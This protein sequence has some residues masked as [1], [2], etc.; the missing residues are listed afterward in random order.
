MVPCT[1]FYIQGTCFQVL[2]S[3]NKICFEVY[4]CYVLTYF[5]VFIIMSTKLWRLFLWVFL[6]LIFSDRYWFSKLAWGLGYPPTFCIISFHFHFVLRIDPTKLWCEIFLLFGR[7]ITCV[8]GA[9]LIMGALDST[10]F[11]LGSYVKL[12]FL[13]LGVLFSLAMILHWILIPLLLRYLSGFIP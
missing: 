8:V 1:I 10:L 7:G 11:S 12:F 2:Y 5:L 3:A 9:Y 6:W 4:I 13:D